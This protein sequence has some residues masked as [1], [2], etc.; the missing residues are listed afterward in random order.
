[1][2]LLEQENEVR[3]VPGTFV[4]DAFFAQ[5]FQVDVAVAIEDGEGFALLDDVSA[6]LGLGRGSQ[7]V[8]GV[9]LQGANPGGNRRPRPFCQSL[10][11][12]HDCTGNQLG[13]G[14][15]IGTFCPEPV[16]GSC[17]YAS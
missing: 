15:I 2:G 11:I 5:A 8:K 7:D 3:E 4:I 1:M 6:L 12:F 10:T 13:W 14:S 17:A 9:F 16:A